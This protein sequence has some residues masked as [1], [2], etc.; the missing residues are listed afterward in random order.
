M[1]LPDCLKDGKNN[2]EGLCEYCLTAPAEGIVQPYNAHICEE[3]Y[4]DNHSRY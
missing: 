2:P 3:C 1:R 4:D